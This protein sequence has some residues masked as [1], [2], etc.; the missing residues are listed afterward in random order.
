MNSSNLL[1]PFVLV[2]LTSCVE[3][4]MCRPSIS[5]IPATPNFE[6]PIGSNTN[7]QSLRE[8]S[9]GYDWQIDRAQSL[10]LE[11]YEQQER[12]LGFIRN[13]D[14]W[15]WQFLTDFSRCTLK[16]R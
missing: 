16:G 6:K 2:L 3:P 4:P 8:L 1:L 7:R 10:K 13:V 14:P 11:E 15:F 9:Q 12:E 5:P